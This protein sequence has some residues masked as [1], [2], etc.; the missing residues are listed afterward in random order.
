MTP[1]A[2]L[3]DAF[4]RILETALATLDGL[5]VDALATQPADAANSV[6]WLV[7]HLARV[8]DDHVAGV[9]DLEQVWTTQGY[10][11]RFGLG[12]DPADL[13]YGHTSAEVAQVRAS[14]DA[15]AAYLRAVT[16][17]TLAFVDSLAPTDLDTVVD[18]HWDPPVTMGARL[19]SVI[20]DDLQH[21]GQ[22]A[23]VRG[24]LGPV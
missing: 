2:L 1:A 16:E 5:E 22:A 13:G 9:A 11:V 23:Y 7:W 19:V 17:Q 6:G 21:A 3:T 24:L 8:Q 20:G 10:A 15:L 4:D 14:A 18:A 12:L